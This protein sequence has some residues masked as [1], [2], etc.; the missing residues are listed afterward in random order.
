MAHPGIMWA[1]GE[2]YHRCYDR[3]CWVSAI[4]RSFDKRRKACVVIGLM[5]EPAVEGQPVDNIIIVDLN[6]PRSSTSHSRLHN[7]TTQYT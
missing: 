2:Q 4:Y 1:C 6:Q 7:I 3:K 5:F